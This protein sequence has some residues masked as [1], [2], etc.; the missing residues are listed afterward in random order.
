MEYEHKEYRPKIGIPS[1]ST[2]YNT[3]TPLDC[4]K[5][6]PSAHYLPFGVASASEAGKYLMDKAV[7]ENPPQQV[8]YT[9][10]YLPYP[11]C[12]ADQGIRYHFPRLL[13]RFC[14]CNN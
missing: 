8:Q 13:G 9:R 1:V 7:K 6:T 12:N 11:S 2:T 5:T 10:L 14:L 4:L 3:T